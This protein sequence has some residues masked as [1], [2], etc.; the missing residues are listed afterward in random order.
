MTPRSFGARRLAVKRGGTDLDAG[1]SPYQ[2][3]G[4]LPSYLPEWCW[5]AP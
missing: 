2:A 3:D 4:V 5:I 1:V